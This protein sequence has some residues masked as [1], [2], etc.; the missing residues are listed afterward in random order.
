MRATAATHDAPWQETGE[1]V[2]HM[3]LSDANCR[4]QRSIVWSV[5][6]LLGLGVSCGRQRPDASERLMVFVSIP[7]QAYFVERVGGRHVQ[8]EV[9]V[10]PGQSPHVFSPTTDQVAR[11]ARSTL[12]F[13]AGLPFEEALVAKIEAARGVRKV[14]DTTKGIALRQM[15]TFSDEVSHAHDH[16]HEADEEHGHEHIAGAPDPH[17]WLNPKN[18]AI[19]A[20][21]IADALKEVDPR[22]ANEYDRNL[23]SFERELADT[24]AR[25]ARA[26]APLRGKEFMVFHPAFGYFAD[27]YGLRQLPVE[28]EGKDP[29][30]RTLARLIETART[31]NIRV[32]FVQPQFSHKRAEAIAE[33]IGGTVVPMDPLARD[34]LANLDDIARKI[35]KALSEKPVQ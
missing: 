9:L 23:A 20:R 1:G 6:L 26:L 10:Q 14:V 11:L 19:M 4:F 18:A 3:T 34:Y 24:D 25:L 32:I 13:R 35:E 29:D 30:A 17:S 33:A 8:V 16:H 31:R 15:E 7:P 27:A 22:N 21:N 12:Y 2:R 5:L 28:I